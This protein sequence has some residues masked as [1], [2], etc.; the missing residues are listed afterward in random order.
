[1]RVAYFGDGPENLLQLRRV[2]LADP[3]R[4]EA[5]PA[6]RWCEVE[7]GARGR[8][9]EVR[10]RLGGVAGREAAEALRG[11]L[12][13]TEV[14]ALPALPE[15]DF[16]WYQLVGCRVEREGGEPVGIV[17]EI[18]EGAAHD[19]LVVTGAGGGRH[20]IPTARDIMREVDLEA[21]RIVVADLPGLI[22]TGHRGEDE[23]R[24]E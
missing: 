9:G 12:V 3:A 21:R 5:D 20:L 6:P 22:E 8:V 11:R 2:A 19:L 4:G 15:G 7:G 16:Y 23:Q 18:W 17:T 24:G 13:V 1:V 10:L 14:A